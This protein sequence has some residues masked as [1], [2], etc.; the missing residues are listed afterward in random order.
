[1]KKII[2]VKYITNQNENQEIIM[3]ATNNT[4]LLIF[5]EIVDHKKGN[6]FI[7]IL[8]L[9]NARIMLEYDL[10][11]KQKQELINAFYLFYTDS[12]TDYMNINNTIARIIQSPELNNVNKISDPVV[13]QFLKRKQKENEE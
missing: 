2:H 10:T 11:L 12:N 7:P 9:D 13:V 1:M 8:I 5:T 3:E 4:C 6:K